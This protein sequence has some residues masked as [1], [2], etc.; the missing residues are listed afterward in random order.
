M[1]VKTLSLTV[2]LLMGLGLTACTN[3]REDVT[4]VSMVKGWVKPPADPVADDPAQV[5]SSVADAL[6]RL[7]G[8]LALASFEKTKNNVVLR[9]I[10][11]NGAYRS[12]TSWGGND[13]RSVTTKNG[14]ITATRGLRNDLMSSDIDQT[15]ALVSSR[16]GGSATRVQRYLDGENQIVAV[17]ANC[18]I[19]RGAQTHVRVGEI[20]RM[21]VEMKE[22]CQDGERDFNNIYR[23][24]SA[25]RVLQSVQWLNAFYG[26]TV[27]QQLR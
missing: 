5:A 15:L 6:A 25:G 1:S 26:V 8:P 12:W 27:V 11:S 21:A 9:Q 2:A 10:A 19:T 24:D 7:D 4:G 17:T 20:N 16:N 22:S 13:R 14:I 18:T 3:G 23:V